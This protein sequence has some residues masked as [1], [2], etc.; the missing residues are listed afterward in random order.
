MAKSLE[1]AQA[2]TK[3]LSEL[4]G[5]RQPTRTAEEYRRGWD[6]RASKFFGALK[7]HLGTNPIT[8][9]LTY[10]DLT[11]SLMTLTVLSDYRTSLSNMSNTPKHHGFGR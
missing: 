5:M 1:K 6:E 4:P 7:S 2:S 9:N 11:M 8:P 10:I 3:S